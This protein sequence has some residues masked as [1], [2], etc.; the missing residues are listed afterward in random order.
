MSSLITNERQQ[1]CESCKRTLV[2]CCVLGIILKRL[3]QIVSSAEEQ[4]GGNQEG[5]LSLARVR[6]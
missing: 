2:L 6:L 4:A 1:K 3:T 5:L